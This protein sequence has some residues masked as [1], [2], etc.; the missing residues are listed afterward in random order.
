MHEFKTNEKTYILINSCPHPIHLVEEG[1]DIVVEPD[2]E[3]KEALN[4]K[5]VE[6]ELEKKAGYES[7]SF[8]NSK[9]QGTDAGR[10]YIETLPENAIVF[11]SLI[12]AQ[13]YGFPVVGMIPAPGF[14][15]VPPDQKRMRI[16]KLNCF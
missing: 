16:F 7:F 15:R 9:P 10:E 1:I 14:E 5:M 11:G 2:L 12:S 6:T 13:A 4:A 3:A 8:V